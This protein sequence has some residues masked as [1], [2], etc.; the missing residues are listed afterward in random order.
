[1]I[2]GLLLVLFALTHSQHMR[3]PAEK[4]RP[5]ETQPAQVPRNSSSGSSGSMMGIAQK[6]K[7]AVLRGGSAGA[8]AGLV[9]VLAG[10]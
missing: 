1:M 3:G 2:L 4:T 5:A 8:I 7:Q 9:Q 6:A 10:H